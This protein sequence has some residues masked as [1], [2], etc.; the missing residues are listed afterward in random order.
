VIYAGELRHLAKFKSPTV[1]S[2]SGD[3]T[4]DPFIED[5]EA[6]VSIEPI[7]GA[8]VTIGDQ[9]QV[10]RMSLVKMRF[11]SRVNERM[12][13]HARGRRF[14][15]VSPPI[16]PDERDIELQLTCRELV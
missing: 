10:A 3:T 11:D 7:G 2:V 16:C 6:W 5:F 4:L 1:A 9:V 15:I 8:E 14:E 12:T 13:L